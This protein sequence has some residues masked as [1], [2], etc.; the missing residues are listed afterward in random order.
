M[1]FLMGALAK[2]TPD[3]AVRKLFH[4]YAAFDDAPHLEFANNKL[5]WFLPSLLPPLTV[6]FEALTIYTKRVIYERS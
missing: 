3:R 6:P 2:T 5:K 4:Y 1:A